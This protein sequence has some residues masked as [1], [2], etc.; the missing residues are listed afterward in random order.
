MTKR[1]KEKAPAPA[2]PA[3]TSR[4]PA[5]TP[6]VVVT[7]MS[8]AGRSTALKVLEDLGYEAV[9]NMPLHLVTSLV[10]PGSGFRRP[11]AIGVDVRTRDFDVSHFAAAIDH[12][13]AAGGL[14]VRTL[15]LDCDDDILHRRYTETR[16]RHPLA[17][18]R[19]LAD[20]IWHERRLV[21]PLKEYV[22]VVIDTSELAP[23]K[24]RHLLK[25]SFGIE[26]EP[27]VQIFVT[28]F[29]YRYGIPRE[30]D[31]VFDVRFLANPHYD[32]ELRP[33]TG[34]DARVADF[35][36]ADPGFA[37]FFEALAG[38]LL[39]LLPRFER[40]GKSYLT[41]ALG[42]T[43]GRHRSVVVAEKL[44]SLLRERGGRVTLHHRDIDRAAAP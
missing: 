12:L 4:A 21:A 23:G 8:G 34:R 39:P 11:L 22:D 7:G 14:D 31:L 24:L 32:P 41:I 27:G 37:P 10:R 5:A 20:G 38:L 1:A 25:G 36:A 9:D 26:A 16:R 44:A 6:V 35:V 28:S 18:D 29:A 30:A 13:R 43:G 40:E 2:G 15:F 33:L 3:E 19:P 17:A 42:C